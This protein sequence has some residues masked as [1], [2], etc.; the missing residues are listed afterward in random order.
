MDSLNSLIMLSPTQRYLFDTLGYIVLRGAISSSE[1]EAMRTALAVNSSDFHERSGEL[2]NS[3]GAPFVGDGHTGRRDCGR[4]LEWEDDAHASPFRRLLAHPRVVPALHDLVGI[5]YRL[6]H[7]PLVFASPAGGEGFDLHGGACKSDGRPY[8]ELAYDCANG[9]MACSLLAMAVTIGDATRSG[10][11][12]FVIMPGSH[13]SNFAVP[14]GVHA[15]EDGASE[16]LH[17]PALSA[18][19]VVLFSEAATHGALPWS[20]AGSLGRIV[21]LYRF[22]PSTHAYGR[23]YLDNYGLSD[24]ALGRLSPEQR[25]VLAPP[26][27]ARL[28]R[29]CVDLQVEEASVHEEGGGGGGGG[30]DGDGSDAKCNQDGLYDFHVHGHQKPGSAPGTNGSISAADP[31]PVSVSV[32]TLVPFPR[33]RQKKDFDK[34]IFGTP[35]F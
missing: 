6:D 21:A 11:G 22:A 27:H 9:H 8:R 23:A 17:N 25:A 2:R 13:K 7:A 19:D 31:P 26:Y 18:G 12:G 5:G 3:R 32:S 4:M 15:L 20:G 30:G 34:A 1:I 33:N 16:L 14:P 29:V 35:Y 28:D 10:E 24:A